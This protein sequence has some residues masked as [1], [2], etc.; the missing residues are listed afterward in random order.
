MKIL[1]KTILILSLFTTFSCSSSDKS[2]IILGNESS[3]YRIVYFD[4][5]SDYVKDVYEK[6][7]KKHVIQKLKEDPDSEIIIEGHA[8]ERGTL[9]YNK[10]L[11]EK[12]ANSVKN[13]LVSYGILPSRIKIISYGETRPIDKSSNEEAWQLNRRAVVLSIE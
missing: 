9:A 8:D 5:D 12:R 3:D 13:I 6:Q 1:Y 4:F 7:I 10:K 2:N 11:G